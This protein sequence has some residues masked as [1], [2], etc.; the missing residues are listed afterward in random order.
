MKYFES[1][2]EIGSVDQVEV[3]TQ[4][5]CNLSLKQVKLIVRWVAMLKIEV[6][7]PF[8]HRTEWYHRPL[9]QW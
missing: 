5:I 2:V 8:A 4:D 3:V 9:L 7:P 1:L 6:A